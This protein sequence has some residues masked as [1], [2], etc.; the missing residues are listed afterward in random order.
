M[1]SLTAEASSVHSGKC[2]RDHLWNNRV[3]WERELHLL[4]GYTGTDKPWKP[5]FDM[6]FCIFCNLH[7]RWGND[8][9]NLHVGALGS[10]HRPDTAPG[11]RMSQ[12]WTGQE[13]TDV[14]FVSSASRLDK[15]EQEATKQGRLAKH[16]NEVHSEDSFLKISIC[17]YGFFCLF[18]SVGLHEKHLVPKRFDGAT[19]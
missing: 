12:K 3:A 17:F 13:D 6:T 15:E 10:Q 16:M 14:H 19:G 18:S 11:R 7:T 1:L 5:G 2:I 9:E 4:L 8:S